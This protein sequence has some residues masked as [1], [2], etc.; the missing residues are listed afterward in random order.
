MATKKKQSAR[1]FSA[2][3][4]RSR[5]IEISRRFRRDA[6][7]KVHRARARAV[8]FLNCQA[9]NFHRYLCAARNV[10]RM[11]ALD[12]KV[13]RRIFANDFCGN[14]SSLPPSVSLVWMAVES[15]GAVVV[16]CRHARSSV[17]VRPSRGESRKQR[18]KENE[19]ALVCVST[20]A[21]VGGVRARN[22]TVQKPSL[23]SP[24]PPRLLG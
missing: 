13:A 16:A 19:N 8:V 24:P 20:R 5:P 14:V 15:R 23:R 18:E 3:Q 11:R 2:T 12:G 22:E 9:C 10:P 21:H 17:A 1:D 4:E 6:P 7:R